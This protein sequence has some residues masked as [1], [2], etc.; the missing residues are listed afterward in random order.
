MT[1][2]LKTRQEKPP[3]KIDINA[4]WVFRN[5]LRHPTA[6][7]ITREKS[8]ERMLIVFTRA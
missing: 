6:T 4:N 7:T 2:N 8:V 1:H 5:A 3:A